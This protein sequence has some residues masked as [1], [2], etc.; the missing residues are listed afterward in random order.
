[1]QKMLGSTMILGREKY[2]LEEG[3]VSAALSSAFTSPGAV[4]CVTA[5]RKVVR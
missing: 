3:R 5:C 2:A 4:R 1:M